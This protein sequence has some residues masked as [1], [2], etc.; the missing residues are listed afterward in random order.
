MLRVVDDL[1]VTL[2]AASHSDVRAVEHRIRVPGKPACVRGDA[3]G[4]SQGQR[5]HREGCAAD[6]ADEGGAEP[7]EEGGREGVDQRPAEEEG[8]HRVT[9]LVRCRLERWRRRPRV[10]SR[11]AAVASYGRP[12]SRTTCCPPVPPRLFSLTRA[13][14]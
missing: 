9:L 7:D 8:S 13:R 10:S 4:N 1:P 5:S 2:A 12:E 11:P 14:V 6:P 3:G